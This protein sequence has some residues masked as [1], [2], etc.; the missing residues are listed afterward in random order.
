VLLLQTTVYEVVGAQ[1]ILTSGYS[2]AEAM[3]VLTDLETNGQKSAE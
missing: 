3:V 1:E 2:T